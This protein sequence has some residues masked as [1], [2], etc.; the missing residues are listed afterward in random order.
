MLRLKLS[1]RRESEMERRAGRMFLRDA[2]AACLCLHARREQDASHTANA[3]EDRRQR[4][5]ALGAQIRSTRP[6]YT[7]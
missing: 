5:V 2:A 1:P 4:R 6:A 3:P 7:E